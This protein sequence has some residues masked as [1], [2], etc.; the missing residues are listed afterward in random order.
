MD[1]QV[2]LEQS[3]SNVRD[4]FT[5]SGPCVCCGQPSEQVWTCRREYDLERWVSGSSSKPIKQLYKDP[6]GDTVQGEVE[7]KLPYCPEHFQQTKRLENYHRRQR[8]VAVI[9]GAAG[10]LLYFVLFGIDWI[11]A[12]ETNIEMGFRMCAMPILVFGGFAGLA[13][14]AFTAWNERKAAQPEFSDYPID[15][16]DGG[17]CG[18][19]VTVMNERRGRVGQMVSY[20]LRL[21]FKNPDAARRFKRKYPDARA[22]KGK[23][24]LA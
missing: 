24:L 14:L 17:G 7:L 22:L 21:D 6:D 9:L 10:I 23:S 12:A 1:I 15:S 3:L 20:F 16:P 5:L 11:G 4:T 8:K 13:V 2:M 19:G 18:L